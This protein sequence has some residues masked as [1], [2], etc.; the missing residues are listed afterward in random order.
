MMVKCGL[1]CPSAA[2]NTE[3]KAILICSV[4]A[5]VVTEI[6]VLSSPKGVLGVNCFLESRTGFPL[7]QTTP[8]IFLLLSSIF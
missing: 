2:H 3:R 1:P 7:P 8:F 4:P 5:G 6:K